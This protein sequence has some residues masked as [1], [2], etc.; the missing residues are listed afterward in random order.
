[1]GS[2]AGFLSRNGKSQGEI[3][4]VINCISSAP[5]SLKK[6]VQVIAEDGLT[7]AAVEMAALTARSELGSLTNVFTSA[8]Y[9]RHL[10]EVMVK[11]ALT[12]LKDLPG[13]TRSK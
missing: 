4:L 12:E 13:K 1:M 11:R 8:G 3:R 5:I 7:D 2:I 6:T 9:K 10:A